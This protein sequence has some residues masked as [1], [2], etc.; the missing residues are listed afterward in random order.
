MYDF[1]RVVKLDREDFSSFC[2]RLAPSGAWLSPGGPA[3]TRTGRSAFS[4]WASMLVSACTDRD[5]RSVDRASR[6]ISLTMTY[7]HTGIRTIIGA[8]SFHGP[9][10]DGKEWDQLAMVIRLE[11]CGFLKGFKEPNL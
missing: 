2:H 3:D 4:R 7:F 1:F 9:V 6:D 8:E 11:L 5:A 10:R